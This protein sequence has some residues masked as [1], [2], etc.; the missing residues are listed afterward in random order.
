MSSFLDTLNRTRLGMHQCMYILQNLAQSYLVQIHEKIFPQMLSIFKDERNI[1]SISQAAVKH[2]KYAAQVCVMMLFSR[3]KIDQIIVTASRALHS[4]DAVLYEFNKYE[5]ELKTQE[6]TTADKKNRKT[7]LEQVE[8][9]FE[10]NDELKENLSIADSN[11]K[12]TNF[13]TMR[14]VDDL[15]E[16]LGDIFVSNR[17]YSSRGITQEDF[18]EDMKEWAIHLKSV[19]ANISHDYKKRS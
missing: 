15:D 10:M 16:F 2:R 12:N 1:V 9:V 6:A 13:Y 5:S 4:L 8:D 14:L 17:G 3:D 18:Y 19:L 11:F 7:M